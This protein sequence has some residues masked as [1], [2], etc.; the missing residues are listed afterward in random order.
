MLKLP[1]ALPPTWKEE[2]IRIKKDINRL[3]RRLMARHLMAV[4]IG[5]LGALVL[6]AFLLFALIGFILGKTGL[7]QYGSMAKSFLFK[8]AGQLQAHED[9][10]NIL[11]LGK[12]KGEAGAELTDTI[13]FMSID[14]K[15]S[16]VAIISIPRDIWMPE[17]D[18]K[19]NSAYDQGGLVLA[20]SAVEEV[21]GLP[22]HY[23]LAIDF[24]GFKE[25]IDILGGVEIEVERAFVDKKFPIAGLENAECD[26]DPEY[27]CRYETI[28]FQAGHQTMNGETALKFARSRHSEDPNEGTDLARAAR[29]Q[30]V[31][32]AIKDKALSRSTYLSVPKMRALWSTF[33]KITETD[34]KESQLAL[35][36]RLLFDSKESVA[37]FVVPQEFLLNPPYS[38]E[39][40]NLY[41]FLPKKGDWSEVHDWVL[42]AVGI[43]K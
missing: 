21:V 24:D 7:G 37:S 18:D 17:L 6:T 1:F 29:Q 27:L 30:K 19:I 11:L 28:E 20:K 40:R 3:K 8:P 5:L 35:V 33:W 10:T 42:G 31:F 15:D 39:Y 2:M 22:V 14:H 13:M 34:L 41:V 16:S 12:A 36:A 32:L 26:G 43:P 23:A 25:V 38:R 9:K 4:R